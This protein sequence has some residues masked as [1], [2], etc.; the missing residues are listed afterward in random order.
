M[1]F[2]KAWPQAKCTKITWVPLEGR[3]RNLL[4]NLLK[5]HL[6]EA[7]TSQ[8]KYWGPKA[9]KVPASHCHSQPKN[10][11]TSSLEGF[12]RINQHKQHD[13]KINQN[14]KIG[15]K[16]YRFFEC[17]WTSGLENKREFRVYLKSNCCVHARLVFICTALQPLTQ[18]P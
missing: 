5:R 18:N 7:F 8:S 11:S 12:S 2:L 3:L 14:G 6:F 17:W 16:E 13:K 9:L 10:L 15:L 1:V 4:L